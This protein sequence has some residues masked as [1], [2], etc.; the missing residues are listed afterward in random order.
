MHGGIVKVQRRAGHKLTATR[1]RYI[2]EAENTGATFGVPFPPLPASLIAPEGHRG[3]DDWPTIGPSRRKSSKT[4]RKTVPKEGLEP[5]RP[6][7][8]RIL[9]PL[10]LPFRHSG[11]SPWKLRL[12]ARKSD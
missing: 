4:S 6:F 7:G 2:I 1:M 10:R 9:S 12:L 11:A 5:S 3:G 8:R